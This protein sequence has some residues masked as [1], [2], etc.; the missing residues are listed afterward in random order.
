MIALDDDDLAQL[1]ELARR[2]NIQAT[3][4]GRDERRR[5]EVVR[6][7]LAMWAAREEEVWT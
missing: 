4:E 1:D 3:G 6:R 7:L 5:A 2:L